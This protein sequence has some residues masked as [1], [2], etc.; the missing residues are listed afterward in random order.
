MVM[1]LKA[2][3]AEQKNIVD[4][5]INELAQGW[6]KSDSRDC[7]PAAA[8]EYSLT[9]GGK[10][11]RPIL[12]MASYRGCGG[13]NERA[14][15]AAVA[16]ELIHT[17]T[18]IHD[19]LPSMDDDDFRRGM[20]TCHR[21]FGVRTAT[22]A[23]PSMLLAAFGELDGCCSELA[24]SDQASARALASVASA[25][26]GGGVI[27]GQVVDLE[28]ERREI[29]RDTLHYIHSHKTAALLRVSCTLGGVLAGADERQLA[30][31]AS[32]GE[33]IGLAFQIVD[34][35]LD[36]EGDSAQLGKTAGADQARGKATFPSL[37]GLAESRKL[38]GEA[39]KR[40]CAML[41]EHNLDPDGVLAALARFILERSS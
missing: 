24:L 4:S 30:A 23:G 20:P 7:G 25:V 14:W 13:A 29:G 12:A 11:I 10:R 38:A 8:M 18:L 9:A 37:Y 34:D 26:G 36:V 33:D 40:S 35:L 3:L 5:R 1:D 28:S 31:L 21:K 39:V 22:L 41:S 15:R 32:Y 17:Y 6:R 19:D 27:G 2:H 16:L